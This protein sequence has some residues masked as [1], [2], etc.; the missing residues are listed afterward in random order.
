MYIPDEVVQEESLSIETSF[1]SVECSE[2]ETTCPL[3]RSFFFQARGPPSGGPGGQG[4]SVY[5]VASPTVTSLAHLPRTVRGGTGQSGGGKWLGGKRGEDVV[6]RVPVGTIVKEVRVEIPVEI[7][8][9]R[10][11]RE[12]LEWAWDASKIRLAEAQKRERR[13]DAWKSRKDQLEKQGEKSDPFEELDEVEV[14]EHK[15]L[16]LEETRKNLFVMYPGADL[17]SHPYFLESEHQ[18]LSKL[19]SRPAASDGKKTRR[20]QHRIV[21][22]E[23]PLYLDLAKPTPLADPILLLSGGQGGLGNST[24]QQHDDRSPKYA[25]KGREGESLRLELEVKAGGE[26]GLVGMPNAGKRCIRCP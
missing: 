9:E 2:A 5:L 26:V 18:L 17:A 6:I 10:A 24:F 1:W 20:R 11:D 16:A 4:G 19:L 22:E 21:T 15:Q 3:M 8:K 13:W 25:T 12:Q 7:E 23:E 14:D